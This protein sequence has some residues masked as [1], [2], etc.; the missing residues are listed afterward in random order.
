[1]ELLR[2]LH[3]VRLIQRRV[4]AIARRLER[5][6][7]VVLRNDEELLRVVLAR[8]ALANLIG[9]LHAER[10]IITPERRD[11][12]VRGVLL[13]LPAALRRLL[14]RRAPLRERRR[15]H[16]RERENARGRGRIAM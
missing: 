16:Q 5:R 6:V 10:A 2:E 1:M 7:D 13:G 11:N 8:N 4:G 12:D 15:T 14:A 3:E 9:G